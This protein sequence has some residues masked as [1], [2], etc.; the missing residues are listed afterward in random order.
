MF[1]RGSHVGFDPSM[2][3]LTKL[4][5]FANKALLTFLVCVESDI[6]YLRCCD[7]K[8]HDYES[9]IARRDANQPIGQVTKVSD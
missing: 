9:F 6:P 5:T 8:V 4:L 1:L 2:N 3:K 7:V